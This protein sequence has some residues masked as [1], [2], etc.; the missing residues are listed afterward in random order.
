MQNILKHI[1]VFC[2]A[3]GLSLLL[4]PLVRRLAKYFGFVD[5]PAG[6]RIH[7]I[8]IPR[9]GGVAVFLATHA[10][11]LP[12]Y[13]GPWELTGAIQRAEWM[14]IV[15]V[16]ALLVAIGLVDDRFGMPAFVKLIGQCIVSILMY[17]F[18]FSMHTLL[19]ISLPTIIDAPITVL[20]FI[21]FI[22]AFNLI[23]GMDGACAGLGLIAAASLSGML[24]MLHQPADGL[25]L[26]ALSGACLGFLR[27]NFN[28]AS[29]FLGDCGSMFIGFVLAAVSLKTTM[30]QSAVI[31]LL[32]PLLTIGVPAFDVF[33]AIWRR[34]ARK[35]VAIQS[36]SDSPVRVFGPDLD[37][38]H[39]KLL[40]QGF[41]QRKAAVLMYGGALIVCFTAWLFL[42]SS[43]EVIAWI[44]AGS[45]LAIHVLVRRVVEVEMWVTGEALL[46]GI[47]RPRGIYRSIAAICWD[48]FCLSLAAFITFSVLFPSDDRFMRITVAAILPFLALVVH[49]PYK[50]IWA[51]CGPADFASL[52][53]ELIAAEAALMVYLVMSSDI[54]LRAASAACLSHAF[55][56]TLS[57]IGPRAL[58]KLL[59][60]RGPRNSR[61]R[62]ACESRDPIR[63][64]V[65][66]SVGSI[67]LFLRHQSVCSPSDAA[68]VVVA[69]V[70]DDQSVSRKVLQGYLVYGA[71]AEA[72]AII[73]QL[74][75]TEIILTDEQ[76]A[77][78]S[79][80]VLQ[81][82]R[83]T[84]VAVR[85]FS[86]GLS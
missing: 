6:R 34:L 66:G 46:D 79:T 31:A 86:S 11:A 70:C 16:S 65:V 4:V 39:H 71:S 60:A 41:S 77:I 53:L 32:F 43:T 7:K 20:W 67:L 49:N 59:E 3:T 84:G 56:V 12:I 33:V 81:A 83:E 51:G 42:A 72:A 62:A 24:F 57:T 75:A 19:G 78:A 52:G 28:P 25:L 23:D 47:R 1:I 63:S 2:G 9:A 38:I 29:I 18:G 27:Y 73:R 76:D 35:L 54:S 17:A 45:M 50:K 44:L 15:S 82:A 8:P 14:Y 5:I 22:N 85:R 74:G 64:I 13:F 80:N 69:L 30:K 48:I 61:L 55:L 40:R 36:N 58:P 68:R 10:A 37:H 21:F 26:L